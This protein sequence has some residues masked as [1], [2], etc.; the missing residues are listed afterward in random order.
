[1]RI[2]LNR[3]QNKTE[4]I[5]FMKPSKAFIFVIQY[6]VMKKDENSNTGY[7]SDMVKHELRVESLKAQVEIQKCEFRSM[8]YMFES[9]SY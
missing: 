7:N 9:T 6:A 3:T 8:S 5:V 2:E 4:S 1:M